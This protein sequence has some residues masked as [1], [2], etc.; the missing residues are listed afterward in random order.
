MWFYD[1]QVLTIDKIPEGAKAF[2]Y[3]ITNLKTGRKYIGKKTLYF[4]RSK[5]LKNKRRKRIISES[6]WKDY[7]G[8]NK[9][10]LEDIEVLGPE[11]F[12][13]EIIRF[14][15]SKGEVNYWEAKYQFQHDVLLSDDWYN[16]WISCRI[17]GKHVKK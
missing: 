6:D 8:S 1:D 14:C 15:F 4:L 12:H 7:Y 9:E 2:V 13:R 5:K 11:S 3:L 16:G 17:S 10:L